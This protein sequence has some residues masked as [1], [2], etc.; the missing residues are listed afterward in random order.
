MSPGEVRKIITLLKK[1]A[2]I[3]DGEL[4]YADI[5]AVL[6]KKPKV[7]VEVIDEIILTLSDMGIDVSDPKAQRKGASGDG[8]DVADGDDDVLLS[9]S[10]DEAE[11]DTESDVDRE[12]VAAKKRAET[13][14]SA[15]GKSNDPVR[16]YLRKMG[17][18]ALLS[19]E[20]EVEI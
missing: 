17:S 11:E 7:N 15:V 6:P 16:I 1:Q 4:E 14:D 9:D 19:R 2:K 8:A 18:V 10:D 20:G 13:A 12:V 3:T 5:E